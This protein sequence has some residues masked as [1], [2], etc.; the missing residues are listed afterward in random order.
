[1]KRKLYENFQ[2][3]WSGF[4]CPTQHIWSFHP[5][6]ITHTT[7]SRIDIHQKCG[8][9]CNFWVLNEII[10]TKYPENVFKKIVGA[11]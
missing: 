4:V 10:L 3:V 6:P 11:I 7:Y 9:D 2:I 5:G 8:G 1:M